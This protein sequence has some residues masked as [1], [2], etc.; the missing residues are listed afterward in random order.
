MTE[1]KNRPK[2]SFSKECIQNALRGRK[3]CERCS[4]A[5][6]FGAG[7]RTGIIRDNKKDKIADVRVRKADGGRLQLYCTLDSTDYCPHTAFAAAL[8]QVLNAS[9][10]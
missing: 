9:R 8:P 7:T 6:A 4:P 5:G 3:V 10:R 1:N 2:F